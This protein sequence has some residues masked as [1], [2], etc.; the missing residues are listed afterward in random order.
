MDSLDDQDPEC[1]AAFTF[2]LWSEPLDRL[3][4][5]GAKFLISLSAFSSFLISFI[6]L[7]GMED[8]LSDAE[9]T[10]S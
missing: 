4:L 9:M 5:Q 8:E 7:L 6:F 1:H 2:G 10:V 3:T